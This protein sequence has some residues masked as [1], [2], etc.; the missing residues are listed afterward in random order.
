MQNLEISCTTPYEFLHFVKLMVWKEIMSKIKDEILSV[1][2]K[3]S[4]VDGE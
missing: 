2:K 4:M 1:A 3:E